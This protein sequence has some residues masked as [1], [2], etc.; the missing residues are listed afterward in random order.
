V[1]TGLYTPRQ[2]RPAPDGPH[3]G[4]PEF[5]RPQLESWVKRVYTI[6]SRQYGYR[7]DDIPLERLAAILHVDLS[8]DGRDLLEGILNWTWDGGDYLL[9]VIHYTFQLPT[10]NDKRLEELEGVLVAGGSVWRATDKGLERRVDP[11]ATTA[12]E[13]ATD[14]KDAAS[15]ELSVAWRSAY[16]RNPDA[17]D[18]W[19]H[20]IKAAEAVLIPLVAPGQDAAHIGHVIGQLDRQGEQWDMILGFNQPVPPVN[21]PFNSVQTLVGMLRLLYPNPDRHVGPDH[22][23]PSLEE[24]RAVVQLAVTIVQ[25]ARDGEIVR[26]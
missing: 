19:D 1:T 4:V 16:G 13:E 25:W 6:G 11:T 10:H 26:R 12:F 8:R 15:D 9:D 20:A 14:P 22:R 2:G 18:A 21:P 23:T 24:A 5:L 7:R 17:S 3:E